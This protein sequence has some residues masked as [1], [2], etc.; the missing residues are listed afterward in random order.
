MGEEEAGKS[1]LDP[2]ELEVVQTFLDAGVRFL[3]V[4]G[5]AVQ[6]HGYARPAEDLDLLVELSAENWPKLQIALRPLNDSVKPFNELSQQ[7]KYKRTLRVYST[8]EF[9]TEID[10]VSFA[11]AWSEGVECTFEGLQVRVLSKPHLILS[12]KYSGRPSDADDIKGLQNL[13][14]QTYPSAKRDRSKSG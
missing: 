6:F 10:G 13:D 12:K 7:R 11:E 4:G 2:D 14:G 5:R 8:V 1:W 9:I 3:I